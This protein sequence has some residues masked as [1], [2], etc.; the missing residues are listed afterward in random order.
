MP[1]VLRIEL[2]I[3]ISIVIS[4]GPASPECRPLQSS[5]HPSVRPG[6]QNRYSERYIYRYISRSEASVTPS[7][8]GVLD[9]LHAPNPAGDRPARKPDLLQ[10][11]PEPW[12]V[13]RLSGCQDECRW[14]PGGVDRSM[15]LAAQP[16]AGPVKP[17]SLRAGSATTV[18]PGDSW[19]AHDRGAHSRP[20][21]PCL[22]ASA[23]QVPYLSGT[24]RH[25]DPV[26]KRQ[27]TPIEL[28]P[29]PLRTTED[30]NGAPHLRSLHTHGIPQE[31][32]Y[33]PVTYVGEW[34]FT[35]LVLPQD[36]DSGVPG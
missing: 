9:D 17:G 32:I 26:R 33:A 19:C 3:G 36:R 31:A 29:H 24:S 12:T 14:C 21:I 2:S 10:Y 15:N 8:S 22:A 27:I 28:I 23:D 5:L 20:T 35:A 7:L 18:S 16:A 30:P 1:I 4:K 6:C 34:L 13:R 11:G 25:P